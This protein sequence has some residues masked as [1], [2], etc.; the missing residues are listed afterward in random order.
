MKLQIVKSVWEELNRVIE[1]EDISK[2]LETIAERTGAD[3]SEILV[4][5]ESSRDGSLKVNL[6][7]DDEPLAELKEV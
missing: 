5:C 6:S 2:I 4:Y 3:V 7:R 1:I